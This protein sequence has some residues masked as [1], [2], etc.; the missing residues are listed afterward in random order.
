MSHEHAAGK[1][2]DFYASQAG[3]V[4]ELHSWKGLPIE[5]P[6]FRSSSSTVALERVRRLSAASSDG[7]GVGGGGGGRASVLS[8]SNAADIGHL[9]RVS[10][11]M[12]DLI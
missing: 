7:R 8:V 5:P 12:S 3:V 11:Q 10:G 4:G 1:V 9:R 6:A 2:S